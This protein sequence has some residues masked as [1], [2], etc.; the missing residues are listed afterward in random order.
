MRAVRSNEENIIKL[1]LIIGIPGL[2][3]S[4]PTRILDSESKELFVK[5]KYSFVISC[6]HKDDYISSPLSRIAKKSRCGT[7]NLVI[8]ELIN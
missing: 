5:K 7:N 2:W 8:F 6:M 3:S 4:T 1:L